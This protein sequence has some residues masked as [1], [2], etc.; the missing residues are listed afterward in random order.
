MVFTLDHA[1]A[2]DRLVY[3]AQ[4]LVIPAIGA[5]VDEPADVDHFEWLMENV[6]PRVVGKSGR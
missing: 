4:R 3:F 2:H 6:Q 1:K 5:G